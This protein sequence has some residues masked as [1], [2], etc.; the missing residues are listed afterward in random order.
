MSCRLLSHGSMWK[1]NRARNVFV[2]IGLFEAC[3]NYNDSFT[4][5]YS[6]AEIPRI[7]F[8]IELGLIKFHLVHQCSPRDCTQR[9]SSAAKAVGWSAGFGAMLVRSGDIVDS[10]VQGHG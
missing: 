9:R 8:E 6:F 10:L 2:F 3:V 4:P 1:A 7:N 5:V